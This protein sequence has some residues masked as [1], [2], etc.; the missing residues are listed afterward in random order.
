MKLYDSLNDAAISNYGLIT[1]A[2][3]AELGVR[4][5]DLLEWVKIG[6]LEKCWSGVYRLVH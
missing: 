4:L 5:K 6:R 3:A 2:Q 1:S